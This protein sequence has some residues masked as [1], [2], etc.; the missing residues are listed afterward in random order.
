SLSLSLPPPTSLFCP[1]FLLSGQCVTSTVFRESYSPASSSPPLYPSP[2]RIPLSNLFPSLLPLSFSRP[3][4]L[5]PPSSHINLSVAFCLS[6]LTA[7]L[8]PL[9]P[10]SLPLPYISLSL[11]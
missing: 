8:S 5:L 6:P 9:F 7:L 10:P 3:E 11:S 4:S 2:I 1:L